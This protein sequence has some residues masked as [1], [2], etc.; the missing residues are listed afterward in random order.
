MHVNNTV[1]S[2][3]GPTIVES[4]CYNDEENSTPSDSHANLGSTPARGRSP[5]RDRAGATVELVVPRPVVMPVFANSRLEA[6]VAATGG[7]APLT[8]RFIC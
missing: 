5:R 6:T 4:I 1:G 2:L 8:I 3:L 7:S